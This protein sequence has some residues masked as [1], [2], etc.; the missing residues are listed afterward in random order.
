VVAEA[1][2]LQERRVEVLEECLDLELRLGR[3]Q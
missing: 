1:R 2:R 3:H